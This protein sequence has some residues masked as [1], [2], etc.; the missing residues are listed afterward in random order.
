MIVGAC[1]ENGQKVEYHT[2]F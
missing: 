2:Q 1:K